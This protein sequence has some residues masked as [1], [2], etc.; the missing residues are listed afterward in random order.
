MKEKKRKKRIDVLLVEK[1]MA[2][3][4][5]KARALVMS[6]V[7]LADEQRID[8]PGMLVALDAS[9]R[10]KGSAQPYVSRGGLKLEG[11]LNDF[12]PYGLRVAGKVAADF[13]ASTGGF[14]DVLLQR[15]IKRVHAIDVGHGLLHE[16]IAADP[17]VVVRDR[18]NARNLTAADLGEAVEVVVIDASF[19]GLGKLLGAAWSV[20]ADGGELV[21]LIKPQFEAGRELVRKGKGVIRDPEVRDQVVKETIDQVSKSGFEVVADAP[22]VIRGP[23]G[24]SEHFVY[25]RKARK[26]G[27]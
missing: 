10:I 5:A 7:V 2:S 11:A 18:T 27:E 8:K 26:M 3:S 4:R 22:C 17:R 19:I 12:E 23:K 13:G 6:G 25:A 9:L 15:G 16:R 21:A 24:N 14:V 1:G 20:L